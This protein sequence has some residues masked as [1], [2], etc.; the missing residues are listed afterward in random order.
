MLITAM[1]VHKPSCVNMCMNRGI[2][3]GGFC[4]CK[5][6][7]WG[8]DC[9]R[10]KA[11]APHNAHSSVTALKIY[12]YELPTH[13]AFDMERFVGFQGEAYRAWLVLFGI[14]SGMTAALAGSALTWHF[15]PSLQVAA[16]SLTCSMHFCQWLCC[17]KTALTHLCLACSW[18]H[19]DT[20]CPP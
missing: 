8:K 4:H 3:K 6:G 17:S 20:P 5:P 7:Y 2:C 13:L 10:S 9:S 18:N 12:T 16:C 15:L 11:F 1:Q 14:L 19:V